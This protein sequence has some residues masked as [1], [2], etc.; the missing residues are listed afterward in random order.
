[1]AGGISSATDFL[2]TAARSYL[3]SAYANPPI[4]SGDV[5]D[6]ALGWIP[7]LN[8]YVNNQL[9]LIEASEKPYPAIFR[10]RRAEMAEV[11]API[12]VYC[13]CPEEAYAKAQSEA[14][15]LEKHGYGLFT[16]N[17]AGQVTCKFPAIPIAQHI[18]DSQYK[19]DTNS[20]PPPLKRR[21]KECFDLYKRNSPAGVSNVSEVVEG[22]IMRA[23]KD[24][25]K[26]TWITNAQ[27]KGALANV[28]IAMQA[29]PQFSNADTVLGGARLFVSRYRNN[30]H[31][32]PKNKKQAFRKY[33]DC[34]HAFLEGIRTIVDLRDAMRALG[35]SGGI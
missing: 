12:A 16:V 28:L 31:H 30:S 7:T 20:L 1:M 3:A 19:S 10:M 9:M 2:Q 27:S 8:C 35:L 23:A 29:A 18:P 21:M 15:D 33:K 26:K 32:F 17:A 4:G 24:A 5:I 22:L 25:V 14:S 34:R 6:S 11:E 13:I